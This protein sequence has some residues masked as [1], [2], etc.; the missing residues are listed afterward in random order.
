MRTYLLTR[1]RGGSLS[2]PFLA[3]SVT[4]A[5]SYSAGKVPQS[6]CYDSMAAAIQHESLCLMCSTP[7]GKNTSVTLD[8]LRFLRR[9]MLL[10]KILGLYWVLSDHKHAVL[11]SL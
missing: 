5:F 4:S 7:L 10:R 8:G 3:H 11:Q 6:D 1:S 2:I 9:Q